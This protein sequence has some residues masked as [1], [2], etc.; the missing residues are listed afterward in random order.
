MKTILTIDTTTTVCSVALASESGIVESRIDHTGNNH[1]KVIGVFVQDM[2]EVAKQKGAE[3]CA[4]ALSQGPG[5]YTGLRIGASFAKGF[6]YGN[7]I[8]LIAIPTLKIMAS[9]AARETDASTLLCPMI[10][11]RRMEVYSA[12]YDTSLN[13]IEATKANIIDENS[14]KEI[15]ETKKIAFFGNG[16]SKCSKVLGQNPNAVFIDGI[17]PLATEMG[18]MAWQ[19]YN[20]SEFVDV[21]YFEPF[22]L[23]EFI[24]T[25]PKNKILGNTNY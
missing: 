9:A 24:A 17:D 19:A 15:L 12:I 1:S 4:V 3:I 23:K 6:C 7:S 22:Y 25:I 11:A 8:P 13:E 20:N 10:D 21:A 2:L 16:S 18:T 5:S 14:F